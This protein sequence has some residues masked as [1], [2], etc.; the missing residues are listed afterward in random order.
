MRFDKFLIRLDPAAINDQE[1][2][3]PLI[4]GLIKPSL[5]DRR[6]NHRCG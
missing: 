3:S 2:L 5:R 6:K 4:S 1:D